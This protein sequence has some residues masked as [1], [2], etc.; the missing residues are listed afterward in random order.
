MDQL[1]IIPQKMLTKA[2]NNK[3]VEQ[4]EKFWHR[5]TQGDFLIPNTYLE[6][7]YKKYYPPS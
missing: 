1:A 2:K 3:V 5:T 7:R 4:I 6:W